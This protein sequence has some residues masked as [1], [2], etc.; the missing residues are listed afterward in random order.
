MLPATLRVI[1]TSL[2]EN[3]LS[4]QYSLFNILFVGMINTQV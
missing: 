3:A 2:T 4:I 1:I